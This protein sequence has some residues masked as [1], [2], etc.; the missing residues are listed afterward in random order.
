M[1]TSENRNLIGISVSL[2]LKPKILI[3]RQRENIIITPGNTDKNSIILVNKPQLSLII[4]IIKNH[5]VYCYIW[6]FFYVYIFKDYINQLIY[7]L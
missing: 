1:S 3:K 6:K 2:Y 7:R 4:D 5:K